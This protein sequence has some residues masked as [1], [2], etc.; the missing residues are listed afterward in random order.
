MIDK[1]WAEKLDK[2]VIH[3]HHNLVDVQQHPGFD[4][5]REYTL[6][7]Q[8]GMTG[9]A[10]NAKLTKPI[11]SI[12]QLLEDKSLKGKITAPQQLRRTRSAS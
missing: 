9:I 12:D 3:E 4:P 11:L 2:D 7:W 6:P 5:N 1:G 10:Y 8:S